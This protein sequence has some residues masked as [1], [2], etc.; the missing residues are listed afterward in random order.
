MSAV[1]EHLPVMRR[2]KVGTRPP[3]VLAR[4]PDEDRYF[5][6]QALRDAIIYRTAAAL[7]ACPD[8]PVHPALLCP[9]HAA[10]MDWVS[11]YRTLLAAKS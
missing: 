4:V 6:A 3:S 9:V 8:C 5:V 2:R 1:S 11:V 7:K 10:E